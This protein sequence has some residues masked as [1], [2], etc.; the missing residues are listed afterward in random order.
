MR[1]DNIRRIITEDYADDDK[2]LIAKLAE[3]YNP[4]AEQI[5]NILDGNIQIDNLDRQFVEFKIKVAS[6]G[7]PQ[8]VT[9]FAASKTNYS[10]SVVVRALNLTNPAKYVNSAPFVTFSGL[11]NTIYTV[12]H[13]TGLDAGDEYSIKIELM[14]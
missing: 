5:S 1:P 10:G 4:F 9:K 2:E 8:Q 13:I 14:V 3:I 6:D 12:R 11:G 7:T